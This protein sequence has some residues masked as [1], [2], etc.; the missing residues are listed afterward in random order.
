[1]RAHNFA[2]KTAH[3]LPDTDTNARHTQQQMLREELK[4]KSLN[5]PLCYQ[6]M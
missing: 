5:P 2:P 3:W 4:L 1:M 6:T